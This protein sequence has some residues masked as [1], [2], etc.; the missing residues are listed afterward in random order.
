MYIWLQLVASMNLNI[1]MQKSIGLYGRKLTQ[2]NKNKIAMTP[3]S[4][5]TDTTGDNSQRV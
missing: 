1:S 2:Y 5:K 3:L 4:L